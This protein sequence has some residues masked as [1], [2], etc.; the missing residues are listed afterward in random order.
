MQLI[1]SWFCA[2]AARRRQ[3]SAGSR[4][5]AD[6]LDNS[7]Q[8]GASPKYLSTFPVFNPSF[9][10]PASTTPRSPTLGMCVAPSQVLHSAGRR[11]HDVPRRSTA[12][13]SDH[14]WRPELGVESPRG[15]LV[16]GDCPAHK[17]S[18]SRQKDMRFG[19]SI[20]RCNIS[21]G[22]PLSTLPIRPARAEMQISRRF[23]LDGATA[24]TEFYI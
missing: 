6:V 8:M 24:F 14:C 9:N 22:G 4:A 16:G 20:W 2:L 19:R 23:P 12:R 5:R 7:Q 21:S 13:S 1:R 17:D 15:G 10:L 3:R 11:E 18:S